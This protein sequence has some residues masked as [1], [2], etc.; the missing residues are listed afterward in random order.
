MRDLIYNP[1]DDMI[2]AIDDDIV[3]WLVRIILR[4]YSHTH[5]ELEYRRLAA[6]KVGLNLVV[7]PNGPKSGNTWRNKK[8]L[9]LCSLKVLDLVAAAGFEPLIFGF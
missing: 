9:K 1:E 5:Q 7:G 4:R 8:P 3:G 2:A 6:S